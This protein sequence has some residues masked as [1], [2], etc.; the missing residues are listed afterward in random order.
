M[1]FNSGDAAGR[2]FQGNFILHKQTYTQGASSYLKMVKIRGKKA[3][4][5]KFS[6]HG[7]VH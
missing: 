2:R 1:R 4:K 7:H 3:L 5:M 6:V